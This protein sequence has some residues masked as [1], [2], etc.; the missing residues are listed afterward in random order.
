MGKIITNRELIAAPTTTPLHYGLFTAAGAMLNMD[1]RI[2]ASGLQFLV[3]HCEGAGAYDQ[4]CAVS[5]TKP[6][7][8]GS[9]IMG[10]DP[11]WVIA[12][13]RCGTVGRTA[14]E[15]QAA[16]RQ[17]LLTGAQTVVENVLWDRDGLGTI[18]PTLTSDPGT[19]T[20]VPGAPGAGAAIAAL[21][22]AFYAEYG[23]TGTIHVNMSAYAAM[24]YANLVVQQGGAG[25][26]RTP[27]GSVWS[28]G[29]GYGITGPAEVAPATGFVW[30]FMTGSTTI[31]RSGVLP[32][33]DPRQ[34]LDRT[35]NQWDT[36]AEEVF[37]ATWDCPAIFAVQVP[38]A[39]PSV[40]VTPDV[41]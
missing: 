34:T 4:T 9:D 22:A 25:Q 8:E 28:F 40:A 7:T 31:W 5:P 23:Y 2:I 38:I 30:A 27:L 20:V 35:A 19:V 12:R 41:P 16:V 36:V 21:E 29:A 10:A 26:L 14:E 13:K 32:Q 18:F 1:N 11:Y 24:T 37:A 17:Q 3:D 39:A 33:P 6:F 15:M